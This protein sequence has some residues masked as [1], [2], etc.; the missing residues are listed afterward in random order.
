[1][2]QKTLHTL[3][4]RLIAEL[5]DA[6]AKLANVRGSGGVQVTA[7]KRGLLIHGSPAGGSQ[8]RR[9]RV[10]AIHNDWLMCQLVT[11]YDEDGVAIVETVETP[12]A[13]PRSLWHLAEN[14]AGIDDVETV[15]EQTATFS[16]SG[17]EDETHKVTP[18]YFVGCLI[19]VERPAGGT[20]QLNAPT[21][22][23]ANAD[24]RAWALAAE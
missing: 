1:M 19:E 3:S 20:G 17:E 14:Y 21:Y 8:R 12:V 15:D 13:K 5:R 24:G 10:T 18:A 16:A 9:A 4:P 22:A 11:G 7:S 6:L 23:D 2:A